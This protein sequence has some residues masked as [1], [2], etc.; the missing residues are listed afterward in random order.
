[1]FSPQRAGRKLS[2]PR[3]VVWRVITLKQKSPVSP[4]NSLALGENAN[5]TAHI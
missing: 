3:A 4:E 5:C 1:M 2:L